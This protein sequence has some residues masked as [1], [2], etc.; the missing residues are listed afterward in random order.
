[1]IP[2]EPSPQSAGEETED[3]YAKFVLEQE[4]REVKWLANR[5]AN[6]AKKTSEVS[7]L[8]Q[9]LESKDRECTLL[10]EQ[11]RGQGVFCKVSTMHDQ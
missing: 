3:P 6:K 2:V 5:G 9:Q 4:E 8:K 1:M 7:I 10:R 11:L